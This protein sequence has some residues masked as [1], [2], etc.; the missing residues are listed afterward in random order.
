[1]LP[2]VP[3]GPGENFCSAAR[4]EAPLAEKHTYSGRRR[5]LA[6]ALPGIGCRAPSRY[7]DC[8]ARH[9]IEVLRVKALPA[10]C[11]GIAPL[12]SKHFGA[13]YAFDEGLVTCRSA[14]GAAW[15]SITE[16]QTFGGPSSGANGFAGQ[17]CDKHPRPAGSTSRARAGARRRTPPMPSQRTTTTCKPKPLVRSRAARMTKTS[18]TARTS[19]QTWRRDM[20]AGCVRRCREPRQTFRAPEDPRAS[21]S[22]YDHASAPYLPIGIRTSSRFSAMLFSWIVTE[23]RLKHQPIAAGNDGP[24]SRPA[25]KKQSCSARRSS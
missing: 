7:G 2:R 13:R 17:I 14:I 4:A 18:T 25:R 8:V 10:K 19:R 23:P 15:R 22:Q 11:L 5:C 16:T 3:V 12:P 9:A 6:S 24:T 1:M 20:E 21:R